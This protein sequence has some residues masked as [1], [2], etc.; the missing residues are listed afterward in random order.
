MSWGHNHFIST[1][2]PLQT[3]L[4]GPEWQEHMLGMCSNLRTWDIQIT[5][6]TVDEGR[7]KVVGFE[8]AVVIDLVLIMRL[9]G[10]GGKLEGCT[11]FIDPIAAQELGRRVATL[12]GE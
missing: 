12:K 1:F 4:T 5:D 7:R 3:P 8:D 9:S 11:E 10:D 2:P 6:I